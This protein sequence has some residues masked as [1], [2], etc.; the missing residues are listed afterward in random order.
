[1]MAYTLRTSKLYGIHN[2]PTQEMGAS[3]HLTFLYNTFVYLQL[4]N[5]INARKLSRD[6]NIFDG[7]FK[8]Y[9]ACLVLVIEFGAQIIITE[10]GS[11]AFQLSPKVLSV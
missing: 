10:F 7:L 9:I 2:N 5:Q 11:S 3:R 6:W 4:F 1:M 8:N